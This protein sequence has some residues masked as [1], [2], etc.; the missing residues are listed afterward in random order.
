MQK[1]F[2]LIICSISKGGG[3]SHFTDKYETGW[4]TT[5]VQLLRITIWSDVVNTAALLVTAKNW[6]QGKYSSIKNWLHKWRCIS[7]GRCN[8][9]SDIDD[10]E[11]G[12]STHTDRDHSPKPQKLTLWTSVISKYWYPRQASWAST[13]LP[14]YY[15]QLVK[16][17]HGKNVAKWPS[18]TTN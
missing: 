15:W 4:S 2:T 7:K 13:R 10:N 5:L 1:L 16:Q 14:L 9:Q 11:G 8:E 6:K 18:K 12:N 17:I 3:N